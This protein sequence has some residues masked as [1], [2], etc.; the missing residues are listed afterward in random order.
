M[1]K[2][3]HLIS[4]RGAKGKG[5]GGSTFEADD[6]MFA[7]QSAAFI[8]ALCEGPIKGL[9]YGDASILIDEVRLR[10]VNQSTGRI[11][12][13]ANFNNFTVI[14]KNGDATQVVDA[15]FFAEY[16]SAAT[17]KDIGSAELLEN[18]PQY[19]TISSGTFEKRETDYIKITV[20]TTG[21]S[22]I[23]KT[24]DNKGD[25]NTT[26]VYFHIDFNWVDNSGVHH[27]RQMFDTGF[28]GK[29]SGKYA[30]TFGF[31]IETIKETSTINDWSVRVTKLTA[32]PESSDS[33]EV[34]NA[35][36]VDSIEAAIA[37]KLEYPYTAYV[38][39]VIDAEAFNSVPARGYEIDG[40][41]INIP[42]NMYPCDYNG[43]KLTLSSASGFSVGDVISQTLSISS[44]TAAGNDE[45]GY[46]ATATVPA[47]G[48]A[49]G[50]TFKAT[51]ATTSATDE[52]HWE[53]EFVCVA[54]SATTFTYTLNKPF[55]DLADAYKI[56]AGGTTCGG[57]KT[58]VMFSGGLVDKIVGNTLYL[59]N[60][61]G[62]TSA[63]NG[64]ISNGTTTGT[65]TLQSQV[66]IPA[67]YRRIKSSEKP[68]TAEQDW[69]GTYYLSWCNNPA[70]VYHDLI[71]NKIYGLG[72]Y[73]EQ[74]QVNKWELF[75][76]GRYCDEL[77]PAGVAA[78]DLL[79]IHCTAD[80]NY[81]PSGSSG[82][83]EPRFSANLVI[84]GKQEAYK[85]LNDVSSIFRG[86]AYW[87]NGE[88]F[89]VQDSEKDPV[90]QFTNANVINGEFKYEGTGNK[91]RTNSI[92]VN[93]NNPQDYY[94][95]RTEIVELEESLQKD[96]EFVKPEA[97]TAFGCT[98][99]GQARRLG[100][101]KLLTNNWNT[102]TVTF[103]TSLNA[104]FLRPGDIVQVI[105]QH[106][107]GKSWGG[108]I[109]SSSSTTAI[110]IDRK[111]S[112]FGNTSAESGYAVGDYRLTLSYVGY[113]AILAQDTATISSTAYVRGAHLTSITTEEA[114]ARLQ[115]DSGNLVF[116][117]WTPFTFT[118]TKTVS[119]VSNN[120]KTLTVS[121]AFNTAP[122]QEQVWIL[123]R[124]ALAT[125]KTKKEAKLFRMVGM[126]EKDKNLY[127]ITALE[128]NASKFDAVDKNEA[129]TQYR[130]IY[131]PDSFKEVPAVTNLDVDPKIRRAG[132]GGTVNSL[133][134]DWDPATN[135]DGTLYN[136]VRHYE[137]E[138]SQDGEKWHKAGT[139]QSTD[140]EITDGTVGDIAILSGT[141]YFKV[142]TVSLNGVRS[143][144]T[145]S[146]AKTID[147]NRAVGPAEG[148]I[149]T[150]T[151]FVNFIGNISGSFNLNASTGKVNFSPANYFHNDGKN[152]HNVTGQAQL[153][154]SGLSHTSTTGGDEGYVYFD[155]SANAFIAVAFDV[156][157]G[158][159]YPV[160]SSVFA[161]AT[162]TLTSANRKTWTGLDSTNFDGDLSK[163]NV[164]KFTHSRSGSSID[165]YHRV[166]EIISDSE[167]LS[168]VSSNQTITNAHNQAFSKP[169]FLV[170][171][172]NDTIMGKV[173]KTGA[174]TYTLQRFGSSQG[175]SGFTVMGT[176]ESH[177]FAANSS[178]AISNSDYTA[179]TNDFTVKKGEQAFTY[180]ASGSVQNTFGI[181]LQSKT[182]FANNADINIS[183]A[184]QITIDDNSL[185]SVSAASATLRITDLGTGST[186]TDRV[187]S[188]TKAN[189][190]VDGTGSSA[191]T[192]KL[193]PSTHVIPYN[194]S[195]VE[196][197][198]IAFTTEVQ[199]I[200]ELSGTAYYDFDVDTN[201]NGTFTDKQD[202]TTATFTLAD[203]DEPAS[204]SLVVVRV[205]LRDG[206][207]G[208]VKATD[209]VTIYGVKE[210]S[211]AYTVI[212]SNQAHTLPTTT[213]GVVT[214]TGSGTDIRV[215][216]G[217]T[218]LTATTG[219]PS[220]GQFKVTVTSDTDITVGS[221]STVTKTSSND[222]RRFADHSGMA[223]NTAEIEYAVNCE[224][225]QT[226]TTSQ[227]FSKS[228]Q[229]TTGTTGKKVAEIE[230]YYAISI[231]WNAGSAT[232]F[233][234]SAPSTGTYNF[235]T[236]VIS[237]I[238]TG[239]SQTKAAAG[240]GTI[241]SIS[242]ALVT[243]A[244]AGGNV[245]GTPSWSTPSLSDK[246][247]GDTNFIFKNNN[248]NPGTPSATAY[249]DLPSGWSDSP[250]A[251]EA[252]KQLWSSKG[253]AAMSG[254]YPNISFNYTW[255][256]P[257]IHVQNK[258]D[259]SLPN[260][261]DKSSATIRDEI[262]EDD[263]VGSGKTF[264]VKPNKTTFADGSTE[265][266]FNF[267]LDGATAVGVN[268]FS[269]AER[270]KLNRLRGG[271][272]PDSDTVLISNA[273]IAEA[274]IVGSGKTFGAGQK[275]NKTT[276]ADSSTEGVFNFQLDGAT[277]VGVNVFSSAERTKL[278]RLRAGQ[279]PAN[280]SESILN[281]G[282]LE[283]D[284]VGSGKT[285]TGGKP[286]KTTFA[287]GSTEGLFQFTLD[288]GTA[289]SV[290][291]F[292][293]AERTKLNRLRAGQD[294]GDAS[295]SILNADTTY[296]ELQGTKPPSD[297][298]AGATW[299]T[300]IGSQPADADILNSGNFT[301]SLKNGGTT[302]TM[303]QMI[304]GRDRAINAID[305]SNRVVGSVFDGTTSFSPAELLR[306]RA[307]FNNVASGTLSLKD[308]Q[309]PVIPKSKGGF[310]ESIASKTGVL[311]FDAGTINFEGELG[312][313]YG[314][315]GL[316]SIASLTNSN[317]ITGHVDGGATVT[318]SRYTTG[319]YNPNTTTHTFNVYWRN[320]AGTSQGQSRVVINLDTTNNDFDAPTVTTVT[321]TAHT[322]SASVSGTG[323]TAQSVTLSRTGS[324]DVILRAV[325]HVVTGFSFKF[326]GE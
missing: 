91:T 262:D 37:D 311:R 94:R 293:S 5:G 234:S 16:P 84:S 283:A 103:E 226:V 268:V 257:V 255:E 305:S 72:N 292:S 211:D 65:V 168:F 106:K 309:L 280:A 68:G 270:T 6:N 278:N 17:T 202:S 271:K 2:N 314:G 40:K 101:W 248:G 285:F 196:S 54:A 312:A 165:Y 227:T 160:G 142:Y 246:G 299:G 31:N 11:S 225:I 124:A 57:T 73:V 178:G 12:Q 76:I 132:T 304:D 297:A 39:G 260:V 121:S 148:S 308:T 15:D 249:P 155:H 228:Q 198:T 288:G 13:K 250:P 114:A 30:H 9:V 229:G 90:Y 122:T 66:F 223:A 138:F 279:N 266:V 56:L 180:A 32:S 156:T 231:G 80:T 265:G 195:G 181:T 200:S 102:N 162:G 221:A 22:A 209:I 53:G 74:S 199:N 77:V 197:S 153:D 237:S 83:H 127:E 252:N 92:M 210:G 201:N 219:T 55:D 319:N 318:W 296:S 307:G 220:S 185:D 29:V 253:V 51:I 69:D 4:I 170:D 21:M 317:I 93:W 46:T 113:K 33:K 206:N 130:E 144:V 322:G 244:T 321:G 34:Q 214:H 49:T 174:S 14:T 38:G 129:L 269:S 275:P 183:G 310:G 324:P 222:T 59:R 158:Q 154:F 147:F 176:N 230:L 45:E 152:E 291:V 115:D 187:L 159:F 247:F 263:I 1:K 131:L 238:P 193:L 89:V 104:A 175:E 112:G 60:V 20:S 26:V 117:Q 62:S 25:I 190:G 286:N 95:S 64:T 125:G 287:D 243:E 218:A 43:R 108:R 58:A 290:N 128:Y 316:T 186:I 100:K 23:T 28:S 119:G 123:S 212:N 149:G 107:E 126:V 216:R 194:E 71:V 167:M 105:D 47:H 177:T 61:A 182:G 35:I 81:I 139:N 179:Y 3:Q 189:A 143:P 116:V 70:W 48:V 245:S 44:L 323:S 300:N 281:S 264:G 120:G 141:Y 282:I 241:Q 188:F 320:A 67:N 261:E 303:S 235:T 236:G 294:P 258:A 82:E 256:A 325:I 166:K 224:S 8:D 267:Q 251:A 302:R 88:A 18:E 272:A 118:E 87:L 99:R 172:Q 276:F 204:G 157:S 63:V 85:V 315:T 98:S 233:P 203:S 208:T 110:N 151:H 326:N 36:Y 192:I 134:V 240:S 254:S 207:G 169:N 164:F 215:F 239:W 75:Q 184:G 109:S 146:G 10:N 42:T 163:G 137:V 301:G 19:F 306:I 242:R 277:A 111:P 298:T 284:I 289:T 313:A 136:S 50:E 232:A 161:T 79:S 86:M 274:D 191:V 273:S 150:D 27:T 145:E 173:T 97:T 213:A 24:G 259:I 171:Y 217:S 295:K 135:S 78:A 52:E 133:V 205:Q 7:R 41:L 96:T 140:F